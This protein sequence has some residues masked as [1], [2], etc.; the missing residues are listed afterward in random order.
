VTESLAWTCRCGAWCWNHYAHCAACG[1]EKPAPPPQEQPSDVARTEP[2]WRLQE[3][4]RDT[5]WLDGTEWTPEQLDA[6]KRRS[7]TYAR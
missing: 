1:S 7:A 4:E 5:A 2:P 3:R 6:L